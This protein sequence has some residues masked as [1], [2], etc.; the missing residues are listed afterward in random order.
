MAKKE[1]KQQKTTLKTYFLTGIL[2]TAPIGLTIL[3]CLGNCLLYRFA[4]HRVD[5]R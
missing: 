4:S 2:V 5:T 3:A 1:Q